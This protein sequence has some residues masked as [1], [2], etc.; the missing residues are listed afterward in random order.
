MDTFG[1]FVDRVQAV[2]AVVLLQRVLADIAGTAED[3]DAQIRRNH[4]VLGRV[5]LDHRDQ[6]IEQLG[7]ICA[8][9]VGRRGVRVFEQAAGVQA[10]AQAA[11]GVHLLLQQHAAHV[12]VLDDANLRCQRVFAARQTALRALTSVVQCVDV[13]LI[14]QHRGAEGN[15]NA[16]LVHHLEHVRQALVG[17]ADQ[18]TDRAAFLTEA[19]HGGG[20][21]AVAHLVQQ[22]G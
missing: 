8:L 6:Q 2:V 15:T 9:G 11:F 14:R 3:L 13:A 7:G 19:Q 22:T 16:R 4:A 10:Q 5:G 12:G 1:A 18:I 20:G 21:V 17:L